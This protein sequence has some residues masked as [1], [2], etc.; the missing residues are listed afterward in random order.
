MKTILFTLLF[1]INALLALSQDTYPYKK[2][3]AQLEKQKLIFLREEVHYENNLGQYFNNRNAHDSDTTKAN[4]T[5]PND[6]QK[7]ILELNQNIIKEVKDNI[8][9]VNSF[10]VTIESAG[11]KLIETNRFKDSVFRKQLK[12]LYFSETLFEYTFIHVQQMDSLLTVQYM[13]S[14]K[15]LIIIQDQLKQYLKSVEK[16]SSYNN[17]NSTKKEVQQCMERLAG[18]EKFFTSQL[19]KINTNRRVLYGE[20]E[21]SVNQTGQFSEVN[22]VPSVLS[23]LTDVN[24]VPS[25]NVF[26][27]RIIKKDGKGKVYGASLFLANEKA[28][29]SSLSSLE[30]KRNTTYNI[31][32]PEAS[33]FGFKLNFQRSF[34]ISDVEK[35]DENR[36]ELIGGFNYLLKSISTVSADTVMNQKAGLKSIG[37]I[38]VKGGGEW[39]FAEY[40][41]CYAILN[42][43]VVVQNSSVYQQ[44]FSLGTEQMSLT[45]FNLGINTNLTFSNDQNN[46]KVGLDFVVNNSQI[47]RLYNSS[48]LLIPSLRF[49]Y[50]PNLGKSF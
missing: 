25:I 33:K 28:V 18:L 7:F 16:D 48:D 4:V 31:L 29:D 34:L 2:L 1:A 40:F 39:F 13:D 19:T 44:Y 11:K 35:R 45:F 22:T 21:K 24:I 10:T 17:Y 3:E 50:T 14:A 36:I 41:S 49:T 9:K 5:L 8:N 43:I 37:L 12:K 42:Y 23:G 6:T 30:L 47:Q 46:I 27:Q 15:V 32:Q 20:V 26:A 38:H